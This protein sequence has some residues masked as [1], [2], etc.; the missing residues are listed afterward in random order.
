MHTHNADLKIFDHVFIFHHTCRP[1]P[2]SAS[3]STKEKKNIERLISKSSPQLSRAAE[4]RSSAAMVAEAAALKKQKSNSEDDTPEKVV[5]MEQKV[6][7]FRPRSQT[8]GGPLRSA[9]CANSPVNQFELTAALKAIQDGNGKKE[10]E[11]RLLRRR[12]SVEQPVKVLT[13]ERKHKEQKKTESRE[14]STSPTPDTEKE[15]DKST[16]PSWVTLAKASDHVV[17]FY[18]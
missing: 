8:T 2:P 10:G 1:R 11:S 6:T 16:V 7:S 14:R 5:A 3:L 9:S 18:C 13:L 17:F 4:N 12:K 15:E